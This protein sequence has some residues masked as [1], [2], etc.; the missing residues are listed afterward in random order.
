LV[1][2]NISDTIGHRKQVPKP[3]KRDDSN[4]IW[5]C[6]EWTENS[7]DFRYK[8]IIPNF[9]GAAS[10]VGFRISGSWD[11]KYNFI[12]FRCLRAR[13]NDQHK[14]K[15]A[16]L[17]NRPNMKLKKPN[18]EAIP[19]NK[20]TQRPVRITQAERDA[21][22]EE[23]ATN[24]DVETCNFGVCVYWD[25]ARTRWFVPR[26]QAGCRRHNGHLRIAQPLLCICPGILSLLKRLMSRRLPL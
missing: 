17:K 22:L 13:R 9:V 19:R 20:R 18:K 8:T 7:E 25:D 11:P 1:A 23:E 16:S 6:S 24:A 10:E 15:K 5:L 2:V 14:N 12:V 26:K 3:E 4:C 21:G